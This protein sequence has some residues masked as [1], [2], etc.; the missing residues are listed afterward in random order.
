[1]IQF[2][3]AIATVAAA[4]IGA[5]A[6]KKSANAS[7][8]AATAAANSHS[9]TEEIKHL[10]PVEQQAMGMQGFIGAQNWRAFQQAGAQDSMYSKSQNN[11]GSNFLLPGQAALQSAGSIHSSAYERE[12]EYAA[13]DFLRKS[14]T[15]LLSQI[16]LIGIDDGSGKNPY[17][18]KITYDEYEELMRAKDPSQHIA[19]GTSLGDKATD[20]EIFAAINILKPQPGYKAPPAPPEPGKPSL[21][22]QLKKLSP[23]YKFVSS[24]PVTKIAKGIGKALGF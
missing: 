11:M 3:P 23:G 17:G 9:T 13:Y 22:D 7:R 16:E 14:R 12:S 18:V 4:I 2:L 20:D 10:S 21:D 15:S 24:H 1:M 5:N 19:N 6:A 8:D